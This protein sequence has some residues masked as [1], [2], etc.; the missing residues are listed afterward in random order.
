M[1]PAAT[2]AAAMPATFLQTK[3]FEEYF[4]TPDSWD[5][6]RCVMEAL[7]NLNRWLYDR[8]A[9]GVTFL[10]TLSMLVLRGRTYHVFHVGDT[11]IYLWRSGKLTRLTE[12]PPLPRTRLNRLMRAMGLDSVVKPDLT[13]DVLEPGDLF[14]MTTDGAHGEIQD[15]DIAALCEQNESPQKLSN[16]TFAAWVWSGH[17]DNSTVQVL[18]VTELPLPSR[19][20][21]IAE[22]DHLIAA[23]ELKTGDTIDGYRIRGHS[24]REAW[25]PSIWPTRSTVVWTWPSSAPNP[26]CSTVPCSWS[27]F[28]ARNGR[29]LRLHSPYLMRMYPPKP[30]RSEYYYIVMEYCRGKSLRQRMMSIQ[31]FPWTLCQ[32]LINWLRAC[33]SCTTSASSTATS[34]PRTSSSP[35]RAAARSWTMASFG[36]P[37]L[38]NST[39]KTR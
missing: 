24:G 33:T 30:R 29:D 17:G 15:D 7:S 25:P 34:S 21:M 32:W 20:E 12:G 11:R 28:T 36:L 9:S 6:E 22:E 10:S 18:K 16:E 8:R 26:N 13:S 1:A 31:S 23:P 19:S 27:A 2:V 14:I 35:T 38:F 37:S 4:S 5:V 39:A 3:L